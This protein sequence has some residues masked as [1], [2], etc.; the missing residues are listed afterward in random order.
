M[1]C[2]AKLDRSVCESFSPCL[3]TGA[4]M[5]IL[6]L[7]APQK[8]D[9]LNRIE[10]LFPNLML[11]STN[12]EAMLTQCGVAMPTINQDGGG[13]AHAEISCARDF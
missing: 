12:K 13:Y 2:L 7:T 8:D 6:A 9:A 3:P 11:K 5:G 10:I 4:M 1:T